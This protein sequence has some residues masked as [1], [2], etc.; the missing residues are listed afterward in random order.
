MRKLVQYIRSLFCDHEWERLDRIRI[1]DT[2]V[3]KDI[4]HHIVDRWRCKKCG[5]IMKSKV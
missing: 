3:E 2:G 4:P 1:F 5:F